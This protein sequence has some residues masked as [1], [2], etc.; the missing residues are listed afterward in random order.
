MPNIQDKVVVITGASSGIGAETAKV[1]ASKGARLVLGAR[2]KDRLF[3]VVGELRESGGTALAEP[4]DV[5]RF[6]EVQ[7]LAQFA[8][9]A[10]GEIDVLVN[11]AGI[12]PVSPL[13]MA[14]MEEWNRVID[15][16]IKGVLHGIGAVLPAMK[17][18]G[19]GHII[20]LASIAGHQVF[21][22]MAV[23]CATKHAVCAL[24]EGLRKENPEIRV[25][26]ISPGMVATELTESIELE[27]YR[28][29]FQEAYLRQAMTP[30]AVASAI[31]YAINQPPSVE[32]NE[33]VLRPTSQEV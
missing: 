5:T 28:K 14:R 8:L 20:N 24:S 12:M 25:T 13:S 9:D 17:E 1:L 29:G 11:C 15:T 26:L 4:T 30:K 10:F 16:N 19:E 3:R 27:V 7:R 21:P 32:I 18:R 6:D 31:T 23:Y 2:R 22:N 33:V